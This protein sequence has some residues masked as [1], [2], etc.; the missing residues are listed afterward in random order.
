MH[1]LGQNIKS[2]A[3][4]PAGVLDT[5]KFI[6][7]PQWDFHWQ[8]FYFFKHIQKVPA[9]YKI[10]GE[11]TYYNNTGSTVFAGL[12]TSDEMFLVYF[13]YM[14]YLPGDET[15]D[16][17]QLTSASVQEI[18][19]NEESEL[20]IYPNPSS[21]QTT[22]EFSGASPGDV[23]SV[24]IYDYQ[25]KLVRTLAKAVTATSENYTVNWDGSNDAGSMTRSG[26]YY[27][28]MTINGEH[29]TRQIIRF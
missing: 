1:L 5:V 9:G 7:I 16:M 25:G 20:V 21:D 27:V 12:N 22:I 29:V 13:H 24:S 4:D 28:S 19:G 10:K 14:L 15:Y 11:G 17:E 26:V 2:Y 6:N 3:Y 8:D 18:I 23:I